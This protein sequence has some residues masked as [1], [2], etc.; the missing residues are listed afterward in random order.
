VYSTILKLEMS[1]ESDG[2]F[3][4]DCHCVSELLVNLK[5]CVHVVVLGTVR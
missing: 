4:A 3:P 1:F 2:T 5:W